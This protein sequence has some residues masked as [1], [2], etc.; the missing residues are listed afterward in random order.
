MTKKTLKPY[1]MWDSPITP[2]YMSTGVRLSDLM[3]DSD[4]ETLVWLEGRSDRGVLVAKH[5]GEGPRDLTAQLSVRARVGYGGGD[6]T[7][8]RGNIYFISDGRIYRQA[9]SGGQAKAITPPFG[10]AA[11]PTVSPDGRFIIYVHSDEKNDAIAIC[12]TDGLLWPQRIVTGNDFYMQPCWHPD[13]LKI[14][15]VTWDHPNMP[16]HGTKLYLGSLQIDENHLPVIGDQQLVAGSKEVAIFQPQFS[17]DGRKL[18]YVSDESGYGNLMIYDLETEQVSALT[19][20]KEEIAQPGWVQGERTYGFT[21]DGS[22]II[23]R[24]RV[25]GSDKLYQIKIN[26]DMHNCFERELKDYSVLSQISPSPSQNV[27]AFIAGGATTPPRIVTFSLGSKPCIHRFSKPETIPP[28]D[29]SIPQKVSWQSG[30]NQAI[31]GLYYPPNNEQYYGSGKPPAVVQIHGGPTSEYAIGYHEQAQF[32]TSR[33]YAVLQVNHRGSSGYGRK[34]RQALNGNWGMIDLED[35]ASGAR[36]LS[37]RNLADEDKL[38]VMGGSAG[39]YTVLR[40]LTEYPGLFRAAICLYGVSDLFQLVMETHK[41]EAHYL[42]FLVGPLPEASAAYRERSPIYSA[43]KIVDPI[44]IF[45]GEEDKVVP[46]AQ[47]EMIVNSLRARGVTH[48]YHLYPG[49]GHGFRKKETIEAF[50]CDVESF[51]RKNVI[52]A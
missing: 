1:G 5:R 12:D 32:F 27:V 41:F 3:W 37:N 18:A 34:Y 42:D 17:P 15:W 38:V 16:W 47:S 7:V 48:E 52:F 6:F 8:T 44:A 49:E 4:G 10:Q 2:K 31:H 19:S 50:Y 29:L 25:D 13:G 30:D 23:Y 24:S 26:G 36:F 20:G 39:G 45:Q 9:L 28:G 43:D 33:G 14:A 40:C 21:T 35:T 51:L 46:K 11:S 22:S